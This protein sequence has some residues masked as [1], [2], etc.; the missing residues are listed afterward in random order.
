MK[1]A[2]SHSAFLNVRYMVNGVHII[3]VGDG[4]SECPF[5]TSQVKPVSKKVAESFREEG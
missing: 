3:D 5:R 1:K 4:V 2:E